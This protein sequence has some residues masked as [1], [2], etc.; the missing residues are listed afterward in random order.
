MTITVDLGD[1]RI[2]EFPDVETA[3]KYV[4]GN[5]PETRGNWF[6]ENVIGRGAVDSPGERLGATI[7]DMG[8][9][10]G[11]GLMR[12]AEGMANLPGNLAR[13]ATGL[14]ASGLEAVGAIEPDTGTNMRRAAE[15]VIDASPG[16]FRGVDP[17]EAGQFRGETTAGRYAGNAAE[18]IPGA[19]LGGGAAGAPLVQSALAYGV[20][21]GLLSEA[22]GQATEGRTIPDWVPGVGGQDAEPWAR[23]GAALAAPLAVNA[24][25]R[26]VTPH[27][28]TASRVEAARKLEA[29]GVPVTAGQRTGNP[30]LRT[31]EEYIPRT[32][33]IMAQQ[34]DDFTRAALRRIGED[35][36]RATPE[37]MK[38][39]L[40]RIGKT[41]DDL[42]ANNSVPADRNL[43]M[44]ADSALAAFDDLATSPD[45]AP[46]LA[47]IASKIDD[48]VTA[49]TPI[50]G[51][52]YQGWRTRL[53]AVTSKATD[54][55][56][57][58]GAG[59]LLE[60]LDDA[61]E[62]GLRTMGKTDELAAYATARQQYR[63][64][65]AIERAVTSA[66]AETASGVITP[67][68]L[69]SAIV[70]QGRRAYATGQRDLGG[71]ARAATEVF[72][73]AHGNSGTQQ[74]MLAQGLQ[75]LQGGGPVAGG[76]LL[77][78]TL[79]GGDPTVAAGMAAA[80]LMA[81]A[82]RNA[83]TGSAL[84]QAWL[85]NQFLPQSFGLLDPRAAA[86]LATSLGQQEDR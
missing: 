37:V 78:Y 11:A 40:T 44:A 72:P 60:A 56:L 1:G 8:R 69:R 46:I 59:K 30:S 27:P 28:A 67:Q 58:E 64:F 3:Q 12:G 14:T 74:R 5:Q 9:A 65:L 13:L 51:A 85:G 73:S 62:R 17:S 21:P 34:G 18:F 68:A 39:A 79:S 81:P 52:Q 61:M 43:K 35:S 32:S 82:V 48:A 6:Q 42:A 45:R 76:G 57:R 70:S 83:A 66:G 38:T 20:A 31:R 41:F 4:A 63:D 71:L 77:G 75:T 36:T 7:N 22:A 80:G 26:A 10:A 84:G 23:T 33:E 16:G 55:A 49:G 19:L 15:T 47:N 54:P 29:E 53:G 2:V 25:M 86:A 24:A 50:S